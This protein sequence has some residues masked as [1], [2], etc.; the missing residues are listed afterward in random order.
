[1]KCQATMDQYD[2][3]RFGLEVSLYKAEKTFPEVQNYSHLV[4][5]SLSKL[6]PK[7]SLTFGLKSSLFEADVDAGEDEGLK[8]D[9]DFWGQDITMQFALKYF[10]TI[11][12]G[13]SI[14]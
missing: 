12:S 1:M 7:G 10:I 11:Y 8:K 14:I 5:R 9:E 4:G 13:Q 2:N 3:D 6:V